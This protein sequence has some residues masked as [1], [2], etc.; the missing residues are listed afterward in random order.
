MARRAQT[1]GACTYCGRLLTR[2]GMARHLESCPQRRL[3]LDAA[4]DR[5]GPV[6]PLFLLEA[7]DAFSGAYWLHLEM[8]GSAPLGRLDQ[9][10]RAI[11][12][13]CCGHLSQFSV[14]GWRGEEIAMSRKAA[15][16]FRPGMELTH[17]YDFGSESVTLVRVL[18]RRLGKPTARHPLALLAR[19]ELPQS[20]CQECGAPAAFVC[21]QCHEE[22]LPGLL[23]E[24]HAATHPHDDY[25]E[26]LPI[27]NSPRFGVCGYDGPALAPY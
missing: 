24:A 17:I 21:Q 25:G 5:A 12:L 27:V 3:A 19:N 20:D 22:V 18:G 9:Y 4:D 8:N 23:C 16:V 6:G 14:G 10:L 2:S 7:R 13:E 15:Q 1:K 26:P 11:W